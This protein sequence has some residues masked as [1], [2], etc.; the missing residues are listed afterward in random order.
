MAKKGEKIS[1]AIVNKL[2]G[3]NIETFMMSLEEMVALVDEHYI[4]PAVTSEDYTAIWKTVKGG[5]FLNK[6]LVSKDEKYEMHVATHVKTG[7]LNLKDSNYIWIRDIEQDKF[8]KYRA[9]FFG[10]FKKAVKAKISEAQAI[11]KT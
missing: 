4:Q 11:E 8:Y 10:K 6:H 1:D 3:R 9:C 7:L 5:I 2:T